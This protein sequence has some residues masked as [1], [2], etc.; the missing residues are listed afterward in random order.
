M[1]V[2]A[3]QSPVDIVNRVVPQLIKNGRVPT[4]ADEQVATRLGVQGVV[5]IQ[6][7]PGS[8]AERG[9]LRGVNA[10]TGELGDI[11]VGVDGKTVRR[12]ADLAEQLEQVGVGK[13]V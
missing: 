12:L 6:V 2:S 4:A 9:G 11:I 10:Q 5:V 13:S 8:P 3:S 1:P 7:V